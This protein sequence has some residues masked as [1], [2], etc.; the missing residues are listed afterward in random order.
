MPEATLFL[1]AADATHKKMLNMEKFNALK[2]NDLRKT[3]QDCQEL[4]SSLMTSVTG[5]KQ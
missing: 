2:V 4:M 3:L 1:T 5:L